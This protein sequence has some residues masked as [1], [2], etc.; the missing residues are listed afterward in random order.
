MYSTAERN[1]STLLNFLLAPP[2]G[3]LP[4]RLEQFTSFT[5]LR[6]RSLRRAPRPPLHCR[7]PSRP[8]GGGGCSAAALGTPVA[9]ERRSSPEHQAPGARAGSS[10]RLSIASASTRPALP[11]VSVRRK[12]WEGKEP[13]VEESRS[14][15]SD[16]RALRCQDSWG[17]DPRWSGVR[18]QQGAGGR[19]GRQCAPRAWGGFRDSR[20]PSVARQVFPERRRRVFKYLDNPPPRR[21]LALHALLPLPPPRAAPAQPLAHS[22]QRPSGEPPKTAPSPPATALRLARP[23]SQQ[24]PSAPP[25]CSPRVPRAAPPLPRSCCSQVLGTPPPR[26]PLRGGVY[27]RGGAAIPEARET[28]GAARA[29]Q[30]APALR[31][32]RPRGVGQ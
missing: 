30:P 3:V 29:G 12:R 20:V 14:S 27:H 17:T 13:R 32:S 23:R 31:P 10:A 28:P 19:E 8:A 21:R 4:Q 9:G 1:V 16:D 6:S 24:A 22:L 15:L 2:C 7:G 26:P 5:R 11:R 18:G 25:R